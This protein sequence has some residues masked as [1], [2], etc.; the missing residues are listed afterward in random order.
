MKHLLSQLTLYTGENLQ[1]AVSYLAIV[2]QSN[3]HP[4][5]LSSKD[6]NHQSKGI[7]EKKKKKAKFSPGLTSHITRILGTSMSQIQM[8]KPFLS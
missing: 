5:I 8:E 6:N 4:C 2:M 3:S 1:I 7:Y